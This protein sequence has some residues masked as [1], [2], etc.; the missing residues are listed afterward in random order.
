[1]DVRKLSINC[2]T[3]LQATITERLQDP[4]MLKPS[5]P[6]PDP[7][8]GGGESRLSGS[9]SFDSTGGTGGTGGGKAELNPFAIARPH[10]TDLMFQRQASFRGFSGGA[11]GGHAAKLHESSPFK[12]QLSLR[13]SDLPSTVERKQAAATSSAQ[14]TECPRN[15]QIIPKVSLE[16]ISGKIC[17]CHPTGLIFSGNYCK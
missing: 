11:S 14:G 15:M 2:E 7:D 16:R 9:G 8:R 5:P 3:L 10:A 1:M 6:K 13:I 4:Q 17:D 12:R